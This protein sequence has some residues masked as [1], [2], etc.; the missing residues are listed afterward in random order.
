MAFLFV[1]DQPLPFAG[2]GLGDFP[3][4]Q[5]NTKENMNPGGMLR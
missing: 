2:A 4:Q 3:T 5:A 1:F